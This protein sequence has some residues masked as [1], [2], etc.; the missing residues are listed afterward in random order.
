MSNVT[1][2][3]SSRVRGVV[4]GTNDPRIRAIYRILL[5]IVILTWVLTRGAVLLAGA[6]VPAE[7]PGS[8][9]VLATGLFEAAFVAGLLFVWAWYIDRRPIGNYGLSA[10]SGWALDLA[11]AF[12]AVLV[13]HAVW[14][15]V[16]SALGWIDVTVSMS[17]G[18]GSLAVGVG[19]LFVAIGV[20]SWVQETVFGA[21]P[22]RNAAEGLAAWGVTPRL[23]VLAGWAF[24]VLMFASFHGPSELSQWLTLFVGLGTFTLLYAHTGSLAFPVGVH[25]GVNFS[26][27]ALFP[28]VSREAE[29]AVFQVVE[30][31]GGIIGSMSSGRLPQ[32]LVAYLLLLGWFRWRH[33]TISIQTDLTEWRGSQ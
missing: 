31:V 23:A 14:Y 21:I 13:G 11:V 25:F 17:A 26:R 33:G 1:A 20:N 12:G 28:L 3:I 19:T 18:E 29:V 7:S 30:S 32:I 16:G 6:V 27:V 4:W 24:A 15:A 8:I 2:T 22:I 5:P 10:S 9:L